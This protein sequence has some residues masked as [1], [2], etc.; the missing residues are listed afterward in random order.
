MV[1]VIPINRD[2]LQVMNLVAQNFH[3]VM[4]RFEISAI[5]TPIKVSRYL[6][7]DISNIILV[8]NLN[9]DQLYWDVMLTNTYIRYCIC[10]SCKS[11]KSH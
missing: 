2:R 11:I 6:I 7:L 4:T 9:I 10:L 1:K 3:L 8:K 5:Y